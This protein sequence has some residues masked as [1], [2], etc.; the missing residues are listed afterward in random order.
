MAISSCLWLEAKWNAAATRSGGALD[1][2]SRL[3]GDVPVADVL[4]QMRD[5]LPLLEAVQREIKKKMATT[6]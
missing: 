4:H 2:I 1:E 3:T 5:Q 6:S